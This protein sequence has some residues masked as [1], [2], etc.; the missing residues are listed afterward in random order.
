MPSLALCFSSPAGDFLMPPMV[1]PI[2]VRHPILRRIGA[3]LPD[4]SSALKC[5]SDAHLRQQDDSTGSIN[6]NMQFVANL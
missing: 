2:D 6:R 3:I 1:Q 5:L 4:S